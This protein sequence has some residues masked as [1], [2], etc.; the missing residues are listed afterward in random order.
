MSTLTGL[1]IYT[2]LNSHMQQY[3]EEAV[4]EH[5]SFLQ[6]LF[7][8]E[9]VGSKNAPYA[10]SISAKLVEEL[11]TKAMKQTDRYRLMNEAGASE[12]EIRKAFDTPAR[13]D[14]V[15]LDGS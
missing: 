10:R 1:K 11:L 5:L 7:F 8:K 9:K 15:F 2:T 6:P 3:A 4:E 13:N 12:Q 14:C